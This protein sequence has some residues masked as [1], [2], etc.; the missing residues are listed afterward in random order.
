MSDTPT[1]FF[2]N[3]KNYYLD[4]KFLSFF[5]SLCSVGI[6]QTDPFEAAEFVNKM[7]NEPEKWWRKKDTQDAKNKFL[8]DNFG[9]ESILKDYL[10]SKSNE[11]R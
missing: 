10:F 5:D 4:E 7:K 1:I 3:K 2:W 8:S 9:N 11:S 6:C